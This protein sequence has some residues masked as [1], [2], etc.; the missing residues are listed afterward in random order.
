[1][2]ILSFGNLFSSVLK[3]VPPPNVVFF[4]SGKNVKKIDGFPSMKSAGTMNTQYFFYLFCLEE[5]NNN[6]LIA[7]LSE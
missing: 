6:L 3:L 4:S 5:T 2:T 1:M 7:I